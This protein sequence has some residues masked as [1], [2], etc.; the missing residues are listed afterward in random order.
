M[1]VTKMVHRVMLNVKNPAIPG[2]APSR[3]REIK[4][5]TTLTA[6]NKPKSVIFL[7]EI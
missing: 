6:N 4:V 5:N 3:K 1:K 2:M 7:V